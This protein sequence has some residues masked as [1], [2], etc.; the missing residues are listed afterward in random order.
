MAILY[1]YLP[2]RVNSVS[3]ADLA[4]S[5]Y[6]SRKVR[7]VREEGRCMGVSPF[8]NGRAQSLSAPHFRAARSSTVVLQG[9]EMRPR[10]IGF[11]M[12]LLRYGII[13]GKGTGHVLDGTDYVE[14]RQRQRARNRQQISLAA[15]LC[16]FRCD[17]DSRLPR[18]AASGA[19]GR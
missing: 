13:L 14:T 4:W 2:Y 6:V 16:Y 7:K 3:D 12:L 5:F 19:W 11:A 15:L 1:H 17:S 10:C 9:S 18:R 8:F